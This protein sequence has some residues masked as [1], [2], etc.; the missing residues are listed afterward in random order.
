MHMLYGDFSSRKSSENYSLKYQLLATELSCQSKG[1]SAKGIWL[2]EPEIWDS[3][4]VQLYIYM[5][6]QVAI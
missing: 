6:G 4:Y 2:R 1:T 3:C 5:N